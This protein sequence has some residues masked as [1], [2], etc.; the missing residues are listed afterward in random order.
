MP[1]AAPREPESLSQTWSVSPQQTTSCGPIVDP[2][3]SPSL[4]TP[5]TQLSLPN[6]SSAV[7]NNAALSSKTV[8][9]TNY[10]CHVTN[11]AA[12]L[13]FKAVRFRS[14]FVV[15]GSFVTMP[16]LSREDYPLPQKDLIS[17][18]FDGCAYD[19]DRPVSMPSKRKDIRFPRAWNSLLTGTIR[20][21]TTWRTPS[22]PYHGGKVASM[23]EKTGCRIPQGWIKERG[24]FQHSFVQR[25]T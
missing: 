9:A 15:P 7:Y 12:L 20:Y 2:S 8:L 13:P 4:A 24:L 16:W 23:D 11:T 14:P 5:L 6:K 17:L 22:A 18:V 10:V 1:K 25:C 21:I 19:P 3:H